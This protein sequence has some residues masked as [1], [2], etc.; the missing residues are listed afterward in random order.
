MTAQKE[1]VWDKYEY[2]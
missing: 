2:S 1:S